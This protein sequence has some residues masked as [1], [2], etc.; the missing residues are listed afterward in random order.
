MTRQEP[1]KIRIRPI[2]HNYAEQAVQL[3]QCVR[4]ISLDHTESEI[5]AATG[6]HPEFVA[7]LEEAFW[8]N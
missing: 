7:A 8:S 3:I 5:A 4:L 2:T 1:K 6:L